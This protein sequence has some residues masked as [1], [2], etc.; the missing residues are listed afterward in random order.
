MSLLLDT[1]VW[2]FALRWDGCTLSL[3]WKRP[4]IADASPLIALARVD[5][6]GWLPALFS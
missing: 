4:V 6:L 1:S 5:G 3:C 2:F